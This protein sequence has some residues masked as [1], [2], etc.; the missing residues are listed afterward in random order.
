ML[1]VPSRL[2]LPSWPLT[3]H[4]T[5][6]SARLAPPPAIFFLNAGPPGSTVQ[7]TFVS[8]SYKSKYDIFLTRAK[9]GSLA[10]RAALERP[11]GEVENTLR[12]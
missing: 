1:P 12:V 7:L 10:S 5:R 4:H 2:S 9:A 8:L 11:T 6:P 3:S